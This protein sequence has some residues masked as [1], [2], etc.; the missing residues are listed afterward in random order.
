[1]SRVTARWA[2]RGCLY[3][4]PSGSDQQDYEM[5]WIGEIQG[6]FLLGSLYLVGG[7]V[8]ENEGC[9]ARVLVDMEIRV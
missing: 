1:M 3:A 4:P 7:L 8:G 9:H 5:S 6:L 2:E